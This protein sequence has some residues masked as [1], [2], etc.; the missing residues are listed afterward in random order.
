MLVASKRDVAGQNAFSALMDLVGLGRNGSGKGSFEFSGKEC[1]PLE[2]EADIVHAGSIVERFSPSLVIHLSRHSSAS[3]VPTLSV[4]APGNVS[5]ADFGGEP[6]TVSIAP[7]SA[8]LAALKELKRQRDAL[9]PEF[10]VCYEATHHGPC[11]DAPSMFIEIGSDLERWRQ[12]NA[13]YAL[14]HAALAAV[15]AETESGAA[16]GLGGTHYCP[17]FTRLAL[18]GSL[19][20]GH[21]LPKHSLGSVDAPFLRYVLGRN[22]ETV[23]VVVLDWK[24]MSGRDKARLVPELEKLGLRLER[25]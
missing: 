21:M 8:M 25:V 16:V 10:E 18:E 3:K 17:K 4:H 13:G 9:C 5:G 15:K 22:A 6:R 14:A 20:F 2:V 1:L 19:P 24:G 23:E 12:E 7:A 11:L